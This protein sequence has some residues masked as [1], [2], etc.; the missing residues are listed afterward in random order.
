MFLSMVTLDTITETWSKGMFK[1]PELRARCS[2]EELLA[3]RQIA[4][5]ERR[6]PT[7]MLRELVRASAMKHGVW[8]PVPGAAVLTADGDGS[9]AD[10]AD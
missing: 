10:H 9:E 4:E 1:Q 2:D 3:L 5:I 6:K 8:P 7:E